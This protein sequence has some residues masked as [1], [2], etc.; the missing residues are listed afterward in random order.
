M[1]LY[2]QARYD[3]AAQELHG[4]LAETPNDARAHAL[5]GLCLMRQDKLKEAQAEADQAVGL[6]PDSS[7]T[8]YTRSV[9]LQHRRRYAEA[10]KA[11]REAL[12]LDSANADNYSQL[13]VVL[14]Q[15]KK[16]Q[17]ALDAS[18]EGLKFEPDHAGCNNLRTMALTELGDAQAAIATADS[19]LARDPDDEYAHASKGWALLHERKPKEALEHFREALR[20]DPNLAYAQHGV[21]EALKARNIIYRWMLAYFLWMGRLDDRAK[22]GVILGGYF[23]M[24]ILRNIGDSNPQLQPWFLPIQIAYLMFVV[25]TWFAVPFFNLLLRFNRF[26]RLALPREQRIASNW[27]A[28]CCLITLVGIGLAIWNSDGV[29]LLVAGFGMGMALPLTMLYSMDEGWPRQAMTILAIAMAVV[30][31][32]AIGTSFLGLVI[33]EKLAMLFGFGFL[34]APWIANALAGVTVKK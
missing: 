12:Q 30:G 24:R 2:L 16:W 34:A 32:L 6:A 10:E 14:Y 26:G 31:G 19:A 20:L 4:V 3:Q 1:L 25:L 21:I 17:E 22:W 33:A 28:I 29:G 7:F 23:G 8:H 13:S 15:Q 5:L 11:I 9:V 27:F 18:L